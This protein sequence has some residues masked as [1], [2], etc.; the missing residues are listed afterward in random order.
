MS[1]SINEILAGAIEKY[2]LEPAPCDQP[3]NC[4]GRCYQ[5]PKEIGTGRIWIY[6][7]GPYRGMFR[8]DMTFEQDQEV[9]AGLDWGFLSYFESVG[10]TISFRRRTKELQPWTLYTNLDPYNTI[11]M[12]LEAHRSIKGIYI[13]FDPME[14]LK[15]IAGGALLEKDL[16]GL[17]GIRHIPQV[18]DIISQIETCPIRNTEMMSELYY[19]CKVQELLSLY[20]VSMDRGNSFPD[21]VRPDDG[22]RILM[23]TNYI[24]SHPDESTKLDDLAKMAHMST[25]KLKYTF[26]S[27]TGCTVGEYRDN[28]RVRMACTL[29]Q[30]QE[31]PVSSI[32]QKLGFATPSSFSRFFRMQ[33][34]LTPL[35]YRTRHN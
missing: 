22:E 31:I 15:D 8:M 7:D 18:I 19:H 16:G 23:I 1:R 33:M 25:S 21:D 24:R 30:R 10:G 11:S 28:L 5:V 34:G 27:I 32:S 2:Q 13:L 26:K 35:D 3:D 4:C 14:G 9:E 29:L 6:Q 17:M 12:R 20:I